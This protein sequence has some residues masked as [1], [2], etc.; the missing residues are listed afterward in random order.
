MRYK[1][2]QK[3]IIMNIESIIFAIV[4]FSI[5]GLII[6]TMYKDHKSGKKSCS[7]CNACN[8]GCTKP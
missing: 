6:R 7:G 1:F 2:T 3:D 4:L 8:N 5:V